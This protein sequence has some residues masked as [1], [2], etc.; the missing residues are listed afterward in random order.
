MANF[1]YSYSVALY[2]LV[3]WCVRSAFCV[4]RKN[5]EELKHSKQHKKLAKSFHDRNILCKVSCSQLLPIVNSQ[6]GI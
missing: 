2:L 5:V 4:W 3:V 1:S 6:E